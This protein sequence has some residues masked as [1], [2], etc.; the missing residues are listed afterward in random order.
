[1]AP[2]D[3]KTGKSDNINRKNTL[4][5]LDGKTWLRYS[6]SVWD[7]LAKNTEERSIKHPAMFPAALT[8]RLVEV[9]YRRQKGM[10]LDPFL[11][12][13]STLCSAYRF[14]IPSVG[15]EIAPEFLEL[16]KKRLDQIPG[17]RAAY[18]RLI[19]GDARSM[20]EYLPPESAG[21]CITSP[22]YWDI[23]RQ[24]RSADGKPLRYYG[25][26]AADLGNIEDYQ[27][28]LDS[29]SAVFR[30]VYSCLFPGAYCV[31]I[32]MDIRKGP[33]FFP[34]HMDLTAVM[35][36]LGFFL[37]DIIIWDRRQEY[38][39]LRPLGYPYVFRVNKI[40]EFIMIYQKPKKE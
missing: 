24:R 5:D 13:G 26:D 10:V 18:P 25:E 39:N 27:E 23:L 4:P 1:M 17:D 6:I 21:L 16:A 35:Q 40:H 37:D 36:H 28:F 38:N 34:L 30:Q 19:A 31:V 32:V 15:F 8:D 20:E 9:F 11:G 7:D 33:R 3:V 2:Q 14:G 29:L 12:S 22:P